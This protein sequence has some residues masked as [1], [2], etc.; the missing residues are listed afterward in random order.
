MV[1]GLPPKTQKKKGKQR[2]RNCITHNYRSDPAFA[3][4]LAGDERDEN[5]KAAVKKS[6]APYV[7]ESFETEDATHEQ[8]TQGG[9]CDGPRAIGTF[10]TVLQGTF[11]NA[12]RKLNRTERSA[13]KKRAKHELLQPIPV[14]ER[15]AL[16]SRALV[17]ISR[18]PVAGI[19]SLRGLQVSSRKMPMDFLR[20]RA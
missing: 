8:L 3:T 19:W 18:L 1:A 10:A 13:A 11:E 5:A 2:C 4:L 14:I 17:S 6:F 9:S 7:A 16:G 15:W 12:L 20:P